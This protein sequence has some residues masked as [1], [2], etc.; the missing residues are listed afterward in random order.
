VVIT[1]HPK[2]FSR[3]TGMSVAEIQSDRI[4][5]AR[6]FAEKWNAVVVL[7]GVNTVI[8][9]P[10]GKV[11][12]NITGNPGLAK[13]GSGDVLTG[14]IAS[15]TAQGVRPLEASLLG[16]YLHG[17]TAD[18]LAESIALAGIMPSDIAELLPVMMKSLLLK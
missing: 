3:L 11:H 9:A 1:P 16:V 7:K 4:R 13:G 18:Y 14:I 5:H 10:D 2:E 17:L 15:F 12:V 6:D 8:A